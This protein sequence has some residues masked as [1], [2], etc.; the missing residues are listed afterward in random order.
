MTDA[1]NNRFRLSMG[2]RAYITRI[3][4]LSSSG[5]VSGYTQSLSKSETGDLPAIVDQFPRRS[6]ALA[7]RRFWRNA[8]R[9]PPANVLW[10]VHRSGVI[11]HGT[12]EPH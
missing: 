12:L 2:L 7:R 9:L 1:I 6:H 5:E 4:H 11:F 8:Y 3:L 10:A